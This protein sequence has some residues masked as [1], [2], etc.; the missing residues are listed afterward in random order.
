MKA[1]LSE[2]LIFRVWETLLFVRLLWATESLP[3][4]QSATYVW[5]RLFDY[6]IEEQRTHQN[7]IWIEVCPPT[8]IFNSLA[9][10]CS[11]IQISKIWHPRPLSE[12]AL[13]DRSLTLFNLTPLFICFDFVLSIFRAPRRTHFFVSC[14][15]FDSCVSRGET[16]G[17]WCAWK[18]RIEWQEKGN[19]YLLALT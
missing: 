18:M 14:D 8:F 16:E 5:S 2:D 10:T 3:E 7:Q 19:T 17:M 6:D 9:W 15:V 11:I 12:R 4:N 13:F 1:T